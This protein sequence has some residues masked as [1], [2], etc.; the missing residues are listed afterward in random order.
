MESWP[1]NEAGAA[2]A[3]SV[4]AQA[5]VEFTSRCTMTPR[6]VMEIANNFFTLQTNAL[7]TRCWAFHRNCGPNVNQTKA[8]SWQQLHPNRKRPS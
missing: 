7:S 5:N 2:G 8:Y 3:T 4:T 6:D 1:F